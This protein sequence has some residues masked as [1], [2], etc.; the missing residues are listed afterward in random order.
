MLFCVLRCLWH[1][2]KFWLVQVRSILEDLKCVTH[3]FWILRF[4]SYETK[5]ETAGSGKSLQAKFCVLLPGVCSSGTKPIDGALRLDMRKLF[6][7][8]FMTLPE[9][10]CNTAS[11]WRFLTYSDQSG[12]CSWFCGV[13]KGVGKNWRYWINVIFIFF[14]FLSFDIFLWNI[15]EFEFST[16]SI[17]NQIKALARSTFIWVKQSVQFYVLCFKSHFRETEVN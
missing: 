6:L 14:F 1:L 17:H 5:K 2:S 11:L 3:G 10:E 7:V 15:F 9:T 4:C 12:L 13:D 8:K 16:Q